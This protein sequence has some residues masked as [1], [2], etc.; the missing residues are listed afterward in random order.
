MALFAERAE[1]RL[2]A[3][4]TPAAERPH[5]ERIVERVGGMPLAIELAA[6]RV[7]VLTPG[8]G[9][10]RA[11]GSARSARRARGATELEE[12]HRSLRATLEWT[13]GLLGEGGS[14]C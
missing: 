5:I 14:G 1:E 10:A 8:S 2:G 9:A 13:H 11:A 7:A 3:T 4:S 6:A 12:R